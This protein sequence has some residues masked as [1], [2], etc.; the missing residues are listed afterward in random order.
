MIKTLSYV[1]TV[2]DIQ[3]DLESKIKTF[4]KSGLFFNLADQLIIALATKATPVHYG[5]GEIIIRETDIQNEYLLVQDGL[6]KIFTQLSCGRNFTVSLLSEGDSVMSVSI[7]TQQPVWCTAQALNPVTLLRISRDEYMFFVQ[8]HTEVLYNYINFCQSVL[9][10]AHVRLGEFAVEKMDRRLVN[11]LKLLIN[12]F[13]NTINL[14]SAEIA[15]LAGTTTETTIRFVCRL[16]REGIVS[17]GRGRLSI[18]NA[19]KL[20]EFAIDTVSDAAHIQ[21]L[22][23]DVIDK[24]PVEP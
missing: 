12:K 18:L 3:G 4:K 21:D 6:V 1:S 24:L 2:S 20:N 17:T 15:E 14:T 5:K 8:Q 23:P 7:I 10:Q 11:V 16:K 19:D 22:Y 9:Q 13:G